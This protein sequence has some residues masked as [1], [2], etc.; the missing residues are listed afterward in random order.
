MSFGSAERWVHKAFYV[1][2]KM[3][4]R[5]LSPCKI[6]C[7]AYKMVVERLAEIAAPH[8]IVGHS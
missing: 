6:T 3:G 4:G 7:E 5:A 1:A 2:E 8:P